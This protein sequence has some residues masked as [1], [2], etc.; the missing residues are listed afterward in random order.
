MQELHWVLG[1]GWEVLEEEVFR[2]GLGEEEKENP[3]REDSV[4]TYSRR[5]AYGSGVAIAWDTLRDCGNLKRQVGTR[6][7]RVCTDSPKVF[8]FYL[9]ANER[10]VIVVLFCF[11]FLLS[12]FNKDFP[13]Q[14][15]LFSPE[16]KNIFWKII[17]NLQKIGLK[18]SNYGVHS[19]C[20]TVNHFHLLYPSPSLSLERDLI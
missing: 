6:W 4:E 18:P 7:W 19:D 2:L 20:P 16:F 17:S 14:P 15:H 10:P 5:S 13:Y 11:Y 3:A 8:S 1:R 9:V 12:F